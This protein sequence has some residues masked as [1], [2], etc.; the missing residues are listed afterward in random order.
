MPYAKIITSMAVR[1][2][3]MAGESYFIKEIMYLK[4]IIDNVN[5]KNIEIKVN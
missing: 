3:L 5:E 4:R 2:D 1:D